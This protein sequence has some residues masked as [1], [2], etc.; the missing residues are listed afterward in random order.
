MQLRTS[1]KKPTDLNDEPETGEAA[2]PVTTE[3]TDLK[4]EPGPM[5]PVAPEKLHPRPRSPLFLFH[6]QLLFPFDIY[7][8][9]QHI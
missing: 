8:F 7:M 6:S 4:D 1:S 3:P 9:I 5:E 2:T